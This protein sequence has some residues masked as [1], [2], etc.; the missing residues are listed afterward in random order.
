MRK[1]S[2]YN[3]DLN[4]LGGKGSPFKLK[5]ELLCTKDSKSV[6]IMKQSRKLFLI[7]ESQVA[8]DLVLSQIKWKLISEK[9]LLHD[10][11]PLISCLTLEILRLL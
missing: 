5:P 6:S 7:R 11:F 8:L 2:N 1:V 4:R 10:C 9:E 3:L